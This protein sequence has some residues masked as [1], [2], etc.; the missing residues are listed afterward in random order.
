MLKLSI[1]TINLNNASGLR[2]TIESVINQIFSD[3]EYIIID[4]GSSDGSLDVINE[5]KD[6]IS[7]WVSEPDKGIYNAMNKGI[8]IATG[9]YL[10]FL[11]SGDWLYSNETLLDV[12]KLRRNEDFLYGDI[13]SY[14]NEKCQVPD[15]YPDQITAQ[16]L[17]TTTICHQAI[18]HKRMLFDNN[19]Y[20]EKYKVASD[21]EFLLIKIIFSNCSVYKINQ[22][23]VYIESNLNSNRWGNTTKLERDEV[24]SKLFP[25]RILYDYSTFQ[26]YTNSSLYPYFQL[27]EQNP[28][29]RRTIKRIIRLY[30]IFKTSNIK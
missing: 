20:N 9:E 8:S 5:F 21:W 24:L 1:I 6:R 13:I 4:G 16:R 29:L 11:N 14:F 30:L 25:P 27:L 26:S 28:K 19:Q 22:F 2:K 23:I 18:F 15:V 3:F 10:Q 7:Y 12:F 17:F